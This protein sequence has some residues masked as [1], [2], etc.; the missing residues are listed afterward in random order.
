MVQALCFILK[1]WNSVYLSEIVYL[2]SDA[3]NHS[4]ILVFENYSWFTQM[5]NVYSLES[6]L[7]FPWI[8]RKYL[9]IPTTLKGRYSSPGH[10]W[11]STSRVIPSCPLLLC[12]VSPSLE[13][14][15]SNHPFYS[16]PLSVSTDQHHI[17]KTSNWVLS[18]K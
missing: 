18:G 14:F 10:M 8:S 9:V 16:Q 6:L 7:L 3:V 1:I 11:L 5:G 13:Q 15:Q 12:P 17:F 2:V 4:R